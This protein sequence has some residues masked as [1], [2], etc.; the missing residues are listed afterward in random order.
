MTPEIRIRALNEQPINKNAQYLLYWM[1][2]FRR[3]NHN[4]SL[5]RSLEHSRE[6]SLPLVILEALRCDFQWASD[7]HHQFAI[8]GMRDIFKDSQDLPV[9][10]YPYIEREVGEGT[11]LL[12]AL[13]EN[14]AVVITDD[15]PCFF[16]PRMIQAAADKLKVKLEAVDSNG[17]MPMR[18]TV[19]VYPSA[20]AF[21]RYLQ[22]NLPDHLAETPQAEPFKDLDIPIL[23]SL[24]EDITSQWASLSEDELENPSELI[25]ILPIDHEVGPGYVSGGSRAAREM[26]DKFIN[27]K[28]GNY[29]EER[30]QPEVDIPSGLSPYLHWGHVSSHEIFAKLVKH[31]KWSPA[32]L[33]SVTKGQRSGWWGMSK[34]AEAFL[35]QFITWREVGYNFCALRDDY[36]QYNS[37]PDWAKTTLEAHLDDAREY[38]YSQDEFENAN[39][40]DELWNAAQVQLVQEGRIHN[41]L[42]MLWAKK[43]LEWTESPQQAIKIMIHLN[44]KYG[45]DGRNPN[46]YSGIFW[47]LGRYDRPWQE[48]GIF[49]KIRYMSSKNTARKVRVRDFIKRYAPSDSERALEL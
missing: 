22:K 37:L 15:F 29:V 45:L 38:V 27:E 26:L 32:R 49:G 6:L 12:E 7:R 30:N 14:A 43:I 33:G 36:D 31:E 10:Y 44:N 20:Y 21:R 19:K 9:L 39:T 25:S 23:D 48:R 40:H 4:F 24:P 16:L 46:S 13:A 17:L 5:D 11:G 2:A 8:E 47:C 35:D 41:Y 28:L 34:N 1:T 18:A 3:L 42:R